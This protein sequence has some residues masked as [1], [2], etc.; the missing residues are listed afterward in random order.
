MSMNKIKLYSYD[1]YDLQWVKKIDS[2]IISLYFYIF[3]V[4]SIKNDI[5]YTSV[6]KY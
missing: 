5:N 2:N 3:P 6:I 1:S 4:I